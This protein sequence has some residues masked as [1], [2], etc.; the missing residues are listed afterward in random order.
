V[1]HRVGAFIFRRAEVSLRRE[2][3]DPFNGFLSEGCRLT[4]D[5]HLANS[6]DVWNAS[7]DG[8][9]KLAQ[10]SHDVRSISRGFVTHPISLVMPSRS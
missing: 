10:G 7:I 8:L 4:C 6:L 3:L 2:L 9:N 1:H 5:T